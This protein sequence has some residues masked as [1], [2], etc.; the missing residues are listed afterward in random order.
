MNNSASIN[1][2]ILTFGIPALIILT[3][4]FLASTSLINTYPDLAA[5]ITYDL[6]LTTPAVYFFLIRKKRI[7]KIT[8]L[9]FIIL[10]VFIAS[11]VLPENQ[12]FHFNLITS[13]LIPVVELV[14]ISTISWYTYHAV[15][16]IKRSSGKNYDFYQ[17]LQEST[18]KV[19]GYPKIA[20]IISSE[21]AL[22]YYAFFAWKNS[23]AR[24]NE[25]T[26]H[27]KSGIIAL[28]STIIFLSLVEVFVVH[29]LVAPWDNTIAWIL[30]VLSFYGAL[31]FFAHIKAIIRRP[32]VLKD[33]Q[34]EL[35]NGLF[36]TSTIFYSEIRELQFSSAMVNDKDLKVR[37]LALLPDLE[38]H[39]VIIHLKNEAKVDIAYGISKNFNTLLLQVDD[40]KR[41]KA[42]MD[43]KMTSKPD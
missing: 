41:F 33:N 12:R 14:V 39:N 42:M 6:I 18:I 27:K 8:V 23:P 10:G 21:V 17:V 16:E 19:I 29:L 9:S 31:M 28:I 34:I 15:R 35:K 43:I 22:I 2:R 1:Q 5:G 32:H 3:S 38:P 24:N 40:E 36:G 26:Y 7:P 4:V 13:I 11:I 37:K 30:S 20:K 25:F